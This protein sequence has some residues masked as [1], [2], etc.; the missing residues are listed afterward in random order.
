M[1]QAVIVG[2]GIV[3]AAV[4]Y[5]LGAVHGWDDLVV[6]DQGD[7]PYNPGSTSHA[8]GGVVV[9]SHN[10]LMTDMA[11][12]S[13]DLY[14]SLSA[15]DDR[16]LHYARRGGLELA[17]TSERWEDLVRLHGAS[18]SFGI[19]T[20]L[21]S[22]SETVAHLDFIDASVVV[23]SLFVEP[24]A[25]VK[26]YHIVG[27]FLRRS[28]ATVLPHTALVDVIV[29]DGHVSAV[30]TSNPEAETISA[31]H[32]VIAA[33]IWSPALARQ[34]GM[35]IP[36]MAF[37][38][39]Y[40]IGPVLDDWARYETDDPA[41]ENHYPLVRDIDVAMYYRR[42][43]SKLGIGSYF[44]EPHL[45]RS[46]EVG[47]NALR[48]F[49]PDDFVA[50]W[51]FA[52]ELIPALRGRRLDYETAYNGM[53]AFSVD[54]FPIIG[55]SRSVSG[56]W[57][58]NASWISHAG[59]VGKSVAEWMATGSTEWDMRQAHLY[60]FQDHVLDPKYVDVV[61][62]K[63]YREVYD[64]VHPRQPLSEPRGV[65]LSPFH[66]RHVEAGAM[67][68]TFAGLELPNW[69]ESNAP[70]VEQFAEQIPHRS[71]WAGLHWSQI[72]GAEHL[73]TRTTAGL[74]DLT[75]LSII[76]VTGSKAPAYVDHLCS[77]DMDRPPGNV[78][79]TCWLT[80]D[81]GIKRDLTVARLEPDVFW[82]F[83]GE[84]TLP[85]DLHWVRLHAPAGVR[86]HDVSDDYSAIGVF[87]PNARSVLS[88]LTAAGLHNDEFPYYTGR[89]VRVGGV[90]V[91]AMRISYVGELG[92]EL[93]V[94][95]ER[96]V[97]VWDSLVDA[98]AED[99][100]ARAG[101]GA[102]DSLR[103]EKG[104]RL[105][106]VDVHTEY[107]AYQAG[108]GWTVKLDKPSF[109]G[110]AASTAARAAGPTKRLTCLTLSEPD[111]AMSGYEP[112][113]H[114][115]RPVGYVTSANYGYSVGAQVALAYLPI[116][117]TEPGTAVEVQYF[118][119]RYDGQVAREPLFDPAM[120]RMRA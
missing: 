66:D 119:R 61:T 112:V 17:R 107:D 21:L 3:G 24:A 59:G 9:A 120:D 116:E 54:G 68:T 114:E 103:L 62:R 51:A 104:Y 18:I 19:E 106:G 93:H 65:R 96:S 108:L 43:W 10:K 41:Q 42:H 115:E 111:M 78:T 117:L 7:L 23:G 15:I 27:D 110:K 92:W 99:G 38:H 14:G 56:L 52:Q 100:L 82:M 25:L 71:G 28:G 16:H 49:T 48:P 74:F 73:A 91:Y 69:Y 22:P 12:Y 94:P 39:Q 5:H 40:V 33:N 45:V 109:I 6:I 72:Q 102:M 34:F 50:A 63:N 20:H 97:E 75:G 55:E 76:E 105:W 1:A 4:A 88:K 64:I 37:Q 13:S 58:A 83:V 26:G 70:L 32:V 101:L 35:E 86:I 2:G 60:R 46:E 29:D 95:M 30:R 98:G 80:D 8:P 113:F 31:E 67:F 57:S 90:E 77:N 79:Y 89:W 81:G 118:G 11:R 36:L 84:G 47:P 44:H 53:F 85:L 87:G